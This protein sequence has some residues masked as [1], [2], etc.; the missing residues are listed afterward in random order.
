MAQLPGRQFGAVAVHGVLV[1][2]EYAGHAA[3][4][5]AVL[6]IGLDRRLR[7]RVGGN[8]GLHGRGAGADMDVG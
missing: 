8:E 1:Q 7:R 6:Q 2:V 5:A 3:A 4:A